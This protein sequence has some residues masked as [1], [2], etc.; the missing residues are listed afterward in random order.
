LHVLSTPPAFTLSQDQTLQF[1]FYS[2]CVCHR[3]AGL[4]REPDRFGTALS[5]APGPGWRPDPSSRRTSPLGEVPQRNHV[6][7]LVSHPPKRTR[8]IV[9]VQ[10]SRNRRRPA[11]GSRTVTAS[12][13]LVKR[14]VRRNLA[15]LSPSGALSNPGGSFD[16]KN[17]P[18]PLRSGDAKLSPFRRICQGKSGRKCARFRVFRLSS[19]RNQVKR[20]QLRSRPHRLL[21]CRGSPSQTIEMKCFTLTCSRSMESWDSAI[22]VRGSGRLGARFSSHRGGRARPR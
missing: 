2:S 3:P 14:K 9:S 5:G 8:T 17:D 15:Y 21:S 22:G 13:S 11:A 1:D 18:E 10:F 6:C 16:R 20:R 19:L 7:C 12:P 4:T